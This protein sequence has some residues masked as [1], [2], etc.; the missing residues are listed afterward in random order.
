MSHYFP[1]ALSAWGFVFLRHMQIQK[2]QHQPISTEQDQLV[3]S[4][5]S[6]LETSDFGSMLWIAFL[7]CLASRICESSYEVIWHIHIHS[8][9]DKCHSLSL[10]ALMQPS[11]VTGSPPCFTTGSMHSPLVV[12]APQACQN[13]SKLNSFILLSSYRSM[14]CRYSTGFLF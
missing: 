9:I 10:F 5:R 14:S 1:E 2:K 13:P 11:I 7:F 6:S 8:G 3:L 12:L 4:L